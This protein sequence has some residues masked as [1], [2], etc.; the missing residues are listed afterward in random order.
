MI[1]RRLAIIAAAVAVVS[2]SG[3]AT[4]QASAVAS[5]RRAVVAATLAPA[6]L[7]VPALAH[8]VVPT[9]S[10]A[11]PVGGICSW[12]APKFAGT[13]WTVQGSPGVCYN[14]T[15]PG[16]SV[17]NQTSF[18][19]VFYSQAGCTGNRVFIVPTRVSYT[20]MPFPVLSVFVKYPGT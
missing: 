2:G 19:V 4:V 14:I 20:P 3:L 1:L 15:S 17:S 13:V 8:V 16:F 5:S 6:P 10:P 7:A 11:C 12:S 9:D 18:T